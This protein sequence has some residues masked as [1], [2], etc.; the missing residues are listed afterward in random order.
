MRAKFLPEEL[1]TLK[2]HMAPLVGYEA[3]WEWAGEM[4]EG[5]YT[6]QAIYYLSRSD[7]R[8]RE[9]RACWVPAEDLVAG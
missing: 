5:P 8:Y 4:E 6:G 1:K 2:P 7:A 3:D 9:T